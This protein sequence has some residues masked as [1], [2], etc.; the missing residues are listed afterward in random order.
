MRAS[1]VGRCLKD[2]GYLGFK[3]RRGSTSKG[4][5]SS[6]VSGCVKSRE[7]PAQDCGLKDVSWSAIQPHTFQT[8]TSIHA[9]LVE[10]VEVNPVIKCKVSQIRR[11]EAGFHTSAL[12]TE[13]SLQ[14]S[15][16]SDL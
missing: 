2:L 7:L 14:K 15:Q 3:A 8:K 16:T 1:I 10:H 11:R 6:G 12:A 4:S 13:L 5:G 9:E